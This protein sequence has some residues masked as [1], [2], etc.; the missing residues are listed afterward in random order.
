MIAK[1]AI[2]AAK[3]SHIIILRVGSSIL[4]SLG[5]HEVIEVEKSGILAM[6]AP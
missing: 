5:S 4:A 3:P 2:K 1:K 6:V